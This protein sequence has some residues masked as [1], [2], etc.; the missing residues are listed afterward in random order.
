MYFAE[1]F[2]NETAPPRV[3]DVRVNGF[4]VPGAENLN[5][6]LAVRG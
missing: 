2:K 4:V 6:L 5:V 3:F 1:T